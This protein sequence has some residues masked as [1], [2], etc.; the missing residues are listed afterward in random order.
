MILSEDVGAM[1]PS[2]A[3]FDAA[4]EAAGGGERRLYVGDSFAVDVVGARAAG[5]LPIWF[6]R[7][8]AGP[9]EPV[10]YVRT[11]PDLLPLLS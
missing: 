8:A 7:H 3:I 9:P 1:K 2:R 11:L 4:L 5:W 10:V 6:D